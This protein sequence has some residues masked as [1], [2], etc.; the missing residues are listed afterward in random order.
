MRKRQRQHFGGVL[1]LWATRFKGDC[2]T[3]RVPG[4]KLK[5]IFETISLT[6]KHFLIALKHFLNAVASLRLQR[7]CSGRTQKH[8]KALILSNAHLSTDW[9]AWPALIFIIFTAQ[10]HYA[11][12]CHTGSAARQTTAA[13]MEPFELPHLLTAE[14]VGNQGQG[15]ARLYSEGVWMWNVHR[16]PERLI[17]S[18]VITVLFLSGRIISLTITDGPIMKC[19]HCYLHP[20][21][22]QP[23]T[24]SHDTNKTFL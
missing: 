5:Q 10:L 8:K 15:A 17:L 2:A 20:I 12:Y 6:E 4:F 24:S 7:D 1:F 9:C 21:Y 16:V 18:T 13:W 11:V 14:A 23:G 3:T 22:S 19:A